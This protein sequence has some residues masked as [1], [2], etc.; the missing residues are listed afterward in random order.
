MSTENTEPSKQY[1][2]LPLKIW[3]RPMDLSTET[4]Q[5]LDEAMVRLDVDQ[6]DLAIHAALKKFLENPPAAE[7][8]LLSYTSSPKFRLTNRAIHSTIKILFVR[9]P[10]TWQ[11]TSLLPALAMRSSLRGVARAASTPSLIAS[12]AW[13]RASQDNHRDEQPVCAPPPVPVASPELSENGIRFV[14]QDACCATFG[15]SHRRIKDNVRP[16]S[17]PSKIN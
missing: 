3:Y 7:S 16:R 12:C 1:R 2:K 13:C 10:V 8:G 6:P 5:M 4:E 9:F 11:S 14:S 15:A 17:R